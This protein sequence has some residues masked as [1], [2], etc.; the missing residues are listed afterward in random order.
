MTALTSKCNT[1]SL[2]TDTKLKIGLMV[3]DNQE[4]RDG[5]RFGLV[6]GTST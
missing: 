3:G 4:V 6:T 2:L 5:G 1:T